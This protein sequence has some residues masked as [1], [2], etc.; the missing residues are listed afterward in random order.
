MRRGSLQAHEAA[1]PPSLSA[2]QCHVA[3]LTITRWRVP[4]WRTARPGAAP[5]DMGSV[6]LERMG[7]VFDRED[8]ILDHDLMGRDLRRRLGGLHIA[9]HYST[10][11]SRL[12]YLQSG[13][14]EAF[15]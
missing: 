14:A 2:G 11:L 3:C 1:T 10:E 15:R 12:A 6:N 5:S 7:P 13:G 8:T 9:R 4:R